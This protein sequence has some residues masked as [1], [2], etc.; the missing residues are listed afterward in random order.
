MKRGKAKIVLVM[1][2]VLVLCVLI[3]QIKGRV[4]F[5]MLNEEIVS[6]LNVDLINPAIVGYGGRNNWDGEPRPILE[7]EYNPEKY[8]K[9][10]TAYVT[11]ELPYQA[12]H[13][14]APD[15][16]EKED[17]YEVIIHNLSI[18]NNQDY[19]LKFTWNDERYISETFQIHYNFKDSKLKKEDISFNSLSK[20]NRDCLM[21]LP[22]DKSRKIKNDCLKTKDDSKLKFKNMKIELGTIINYEYGLEENETCI[23]EKIETEKL[24]G[25]DCLLN[26]SYP[27]YSWE[28]FEDIGIKN[29]F[30]D[31]L[32]IDDVEVSACG[33]LDIQGET[34]KLTADII[35][36]TETSKCM[37][38]TKD[39][40]TLN[41]QGHTIDGI[42]NESSLA[43]GVYIYRKDNVTIKNCVITDWVTGITA[44]SIGSWNLT[45]MN[46]KVTSNLDYGVSLTDTEYANIINNTI[47]DNEDI[48]IRIYDITYNPG[49]TMVDNIIGPNSGRDIY[50]WIVPGKIYNNIINSS[51]L[52]L[53]SPNPAW[54]TT[55]SSGA[56]IVGGL[57]LGG[58][59]WANSSGTG[60]SEICED[61]DGDAICDSNYILYSDNTD[62]LPLTIP[63]PIT[64]IIGNFSDNGES[65]SFGSVG[66][67]SI[68]ITLECAN[69]SNKICDATTYCI[70]TTNS[71]TPPIIYS[72]PITITS[73][74]YFRYRSND[75]LGDQETIKSRYIMIDTNALS[76]PIKWP[77]CNP[78]DSCC[79]IDGYLRENGSV[80]RSA[81][82]ISCD[83]ASTCSG[84][85]VEDRC[86]G[87]SSECPN[88]NDP[89]TYNE[90]CNDVV[91]SSQ[92]CSGYIFQ[93][94]KTCSTGTCQINN[95]YDCPN[96]LDC[97]DGSSCKNEAGSSSDCKTSYSYNDKY[98]VCWL[99][100]TNKTAYGMIYDDNGNLISGFGLNHSY[101]N[102]NQLVNIVDSS[103]GTLIAEYFY[104]YE[105]TRIKSII[106]QGA[107]NITVYYFENFIQI[108]NSS[109]V[110]NESY[111]Y[112]YDKLVGKKNSDGSTFF[113][114]VNLLGSTSLV[115]NSSG[116]VVAFLSYG[117][118]GELIGDSNE[119]YTYTGHEQDSESE[120]LYMKAR[121]YNPDIARFIQPDMITTDIYDSQNL[122]R[123]AYVG[124]NPY[125]YVDPDGLWMVSLGGLLSGSFNPAYGSIAGKIYVIHDESKDIFHGWFIGV[126]LPIT[127][128]V[129]V[130]SG[131]A[132]AS[133][134]A[135]YSPDVNKPEDLEGTSSSTGASAGLLI[136]VGGEVSTSDKGVKEY[137]FQGGVGAG[138]EVHT[139]LTK[140]YVSD[141]RDID[142]SSSSSKS[143]SKNKKSSKNKN[144]KEVSN[145]KQKS[146]KKSTNLGRQPSR[147]TAA[148]NRPQQRRTRIITR[149]WTTVKFAVKSWWRKLWG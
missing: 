114:H 132:S 29:I 42:D 64:T 111:F 148:S 20:Y 70:D 22:N 96:N 18:K 12:K 134:T 1:F 5:D 81:H 52:Y 113:Y 27:V 121:Y 99:N 65:Y 77:E 97:L 26:V 9:I 25:S 2:I 45:I 123:Y 53:V 76:P 146:V 109:G 73:T 147:N 13:I 30:L 93:P 119:R 35:D 127:S 126:Y 3:F 80:C 102:F 37:Y 79:D 50:T 125:G 72:S 87:I 61:Y 7:E 101:N 103:S 98:N 71:C 105:G 56:S 83:A 51:N 19:I 47:K 115:T 129:D 117:P 84:S 11:F 14:W 106:Y 21:S 58:N 104:D 62:Y 94:E 69:N 23:K 89:I 112:Y 107:E 6:N 136:N 40:I 100:E 139:G 4:S 24:I 116:D 63:K 144:Y 68:D 49:I 91:C 140:T 120:L 46:N 122:N 33:T 137:T 95:A 66:N 39:S 54:N 78:T 57:Y 41:C 86:D 16:S 36:S 85:A 92:S 15:E 67:G 135:S 88:S 145:Y 128:A 31:F 124:N 108:V 110:Y 43:K 59:Y 82:D 133:I 131:T 28:D 130:G 44:G 141:I 38:I 142:K 75:T 143:S 74:N 138:T 10:I 8:Q 32:A 118:F 149:T 17:I 55:K 48:G 34:Y 90:A 60:F